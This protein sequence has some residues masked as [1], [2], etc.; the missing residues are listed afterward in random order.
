M[1]EVTL[2]KA[3]L[4]PLLAV[5]VPVIAAIILLYFSFKKYL[6]QL[7]EVQENEEP[8][9]IVLDSFDWMAEY[10]GH[11]EPG[12]TA[13]WLEPDTPQELADWMATYRPDVTGIVEAAGI[14]I[15]I[16]PVR[17]RDLDRLNRGFYHGS[18][19]VRARH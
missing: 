12:S 4:V 9:P 5:S 17:K 11:W 19:K 7:E 18:R 15:D 14:R 6:K 1:I 3:L 10:G 13:F 8:E 16:I 2:F